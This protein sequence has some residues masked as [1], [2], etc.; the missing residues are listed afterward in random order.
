MRHAQQR[1]RARRRRAD[2]DDIKRA[3]LDVIRDDP[4]MTVRQV[5][6]QLVARGVIEKTELAYQGTVIRLMTDMRL[7]GRL[8]YAWV[9][10]ESRR[11][12]ITE[13][14]DSVQDALKQTAQ[15]Y[16]RSALKEAPEYL[17]I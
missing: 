13:T 15:F 5:F 1:R 6:Y 9:V 4:P 16:R 3:I 10:D 2:I 7:N 14:Y 8:P 11:V 12:R 17:E